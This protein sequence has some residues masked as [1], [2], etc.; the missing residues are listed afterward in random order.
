MKGVVIAFCSALFGAMF[1]T[2]LNPVGLASTSLGLIAILAYKVAK[3]EQDK[4]EGKT[5]VSVAN[6]IKF[7][8]AMGGLLGFASL[9]VFALSF[10]NT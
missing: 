10:S 5:E 6:E 2:P 9:G 4:K 1:F 7:G 3:F 8:L